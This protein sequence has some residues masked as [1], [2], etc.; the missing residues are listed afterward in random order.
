MTEPL[1]SRDHA[2]P[3]R[4]LLA[5]LAASVAAGLGGLL[6]SEANAA[7]MQPAAPVADWPAALPGRHRLVIDAYSVNGGHPLGFASNFLSTATPAG[8]SSVA[9]V[10]RAEALPIA[11]D[12]AIWAKY[13]LGE[14]LK[15]IDP[16]TR[17]PAVKNPFLQ[18][19]PG[20][21]TSDGWAVD[22][23]IAAGAAIGACNV[24]LRGM[25][26]AFAAHAGVSADDA[27]TEWA[28]NLIPG[29]ALLPS[30]VWGLGRAQE[31]GCGYCAGG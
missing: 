24:A 12:S 4:A 10:L 20:V 22:R 18:P 13:A 27:A 16:E 8:S 11:L 3:R 29:I 1:C 23:L 28:A 2:A 6:A 26:K 30:G 14:R 5:R 19:K 31:A 21:L 15:V 25:S 7:T 17:A 9:L